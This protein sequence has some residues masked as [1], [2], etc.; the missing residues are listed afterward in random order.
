MPAS[1]PMADSALR[2]NTTSS[3][4]SARRGSTR[5]RRS[6][7]IWCC[8]SSPSTCWACPAPTSACPG[9]VG[10]GSPI[11]DMRKTR[12][13]KML[14]LEGITVI[15]VEQA[16]AAPFCSSRLA[17]AGATVIKVERPEGDF[18]RAYDVAAKGQSSYFVWLNR[19]KQSVA[20]DLA[21]REG[22]AQLEELIASADVLLQNL[23][24]GSMD[25][26]GF[27]LDRLKKDYP[28][29]ICCTITGYGDEGPYAHRKAYDL[30]IQAAS[31]LAS[32]TGN[33]D[34]ASRVGMSIVD[35]A[36]G[37]TAHA[38]ILEALIARGR[39][40]KGVDIRISMFDVMADWCTVPLLNA[41]NGKPPQRMGLA[42]PS[43]APYGVFTSKDGKDILISIQSEREWKKLCAEVLDQPGL[44]DDPRFANMVERV[45]NRVLT[46]T[47]V[48]DSFARL[49]RDELLKRLSD[50]D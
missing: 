14:P 48:G 16:V 15:A 46:D 31:G 45:R 33:P 2:R 19:G 50:A 6:R 41:E 49:S 38:A 9:E 30:L 26:L 10:T 12:E 1:R 8:H 13:T 5:S 44:P 47:T 29:L 21:T 35:V 18:A 32:I 28:A 39:T 11:R 23:K 20:I 4:N 3:A 43:V 7:P 40:G 17:D 42:H 27:S 34:G 22:R 36:T 37:A 24:P 25:K